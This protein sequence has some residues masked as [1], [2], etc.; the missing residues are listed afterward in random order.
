MLK[1]LSNSDPGWSIVCLRYFNPVGAHQ[2]GLIG[3]DPNGIPNNL[4][5]YIAQVASGKLPYI[6]VY[7]N[8]Y[9]PNDRTG[10]GD[11]IHVEGLEEGHLTVLDYVRG[12]TGWI[13]INLGT[14]F[15]I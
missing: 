2:S 8:D 7:G 3:E 15:G 1:D 13:A 10:V 9:P 12:H 5:L 4:M 11:Y 14:S 6:N